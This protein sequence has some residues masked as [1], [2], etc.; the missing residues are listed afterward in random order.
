VIGQERVS[1]MTE[2]MEPDTSIRRCEAAYL[3]K[4]ERRQVRRAN[5]R[6]VF[7]WILPTLLA[8][9]IGALVLAMSGWDYYVL[10]FAK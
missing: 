1:D 4:I 5:R 6:A 9:G 10:G 8:L 3:R 7:D 2:I